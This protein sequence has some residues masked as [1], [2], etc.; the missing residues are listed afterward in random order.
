MGTLAPGSACA[1]NLLATFMNRTAGK[2][3]TGQLFGLT[4]LLLTV[5][6]SQTASGQTTPAHHEDYFLRE[7]PAP[8]G[9]T[10]NDVWESEFEARNS[11]SMDPES[12]ESTDYDWL[13]KVRVGYD[14]GFVIVSDDELNLN[15]DNA[16]FQL[17]IT[18]WGQ[19]R[20]TVFDSDSPNPNQRDVNQFQ[21]KRGRLIFSGSA[22]TSD[23]GYFVQL[24]GRSSS[25]DQMRLLDFNLNFDVGH[26]ILGLDRGVVGIRAGKYK[27]PFT[28]ARYLS[29]REF[30]F[31]DRS[32][33]STFFDVNRS[34][35]VGLYRDL[36]RG[37]IPW[38]WE[39]AL[40]N[41]LVTGGA[42][43][44]SAGS[45]DNNFAYSG[46]LF[47]YPT[48]DWGQDGPADLTW[49]ERL[50]TRMGMGVAHSTI[51]RLGNDEFDSLRVVDTGERLS[52][53]LDDTLPTEIDEYTANLFAVDGSLKY[54]GCSV[55]LEYYFRNINDFEGAVLPDLYDHGYWLQFGK[56]AVPRKLQFLARWSRVVGNSGTLGGAD[57]SSDEYATGVVWYIREQHAKLTFDLTYLNGAPINSSAL[58]ITPG[59]LGV[60]YRLQAQFAF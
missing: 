14:H 21:L 9:Q 43:T 19:L 55:T 47:I 26:N 52:N 25:G 5:S 49:H 45:L 51:D 54:R 6:A 53:L 32:V 46:R 57:L 8:A 37:R 42:E 15:A 23:F 12:N 16:P 2:T 58:D 27:M 30:E 38:H 10:E 44:G 20:S 56:F 34:F 33:A 22:F 48:G 40:F 60:L 17:R 18:G 59:D 50:A 11:G 28:M 36:R 35:G 29:G 4:V 41:G 1:I 3:K 31:A 24:D 39:V 7:A 13:S